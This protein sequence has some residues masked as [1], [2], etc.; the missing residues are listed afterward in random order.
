[1]WLLWRALNLIVMFAR[2]IMFGGDKRRFVSVKVVVI[3]LRR[4]DHIFRYW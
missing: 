4:Y 1:L 3:K 2:V